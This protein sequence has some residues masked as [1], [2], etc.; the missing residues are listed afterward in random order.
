MMLRKIASHLW[1]KEARWGNQG[2]RAQRLEIK[3]AEAVGSP[4]QEEEDK[5]ASMSLDILIHMH[6]V[7]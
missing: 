3:D 4:E 7:V 6:G 2:V 1:L 5:V